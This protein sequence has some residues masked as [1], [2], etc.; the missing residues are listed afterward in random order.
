MNLYTKADA[1]K[2]EEQLKNPGLSDQSGPSCQPASEFWR[3]SCL[4]LV[5]GSGW[6]KCEEP[7]IV[8]LRP[9]SLWSEY[10]CAALSYVNFWYLLLSRVFYPSSCHTRPRI[11]YCYPAPMFNSSVRFYRASTRDHGY[12]NTLARGAEIMEICKLVSPQQFMTIS[13]NF[14]LTFFYLIKIYVVCKEDRIAQY[15]YNTL[16]MNS[17]VIRFVLNGWGFHCVRHKPLL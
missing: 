10:A 3:V 16:L 4:I 9:F 2:G 8:S 1:C 7:D 5:N 12:R 6:G 11:G 15:F 13:D 14:T 17:M